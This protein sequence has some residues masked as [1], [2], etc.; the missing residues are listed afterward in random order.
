MQINTH[1]STL[2]LIDKAK[3]REKILKVAREKQQ[4]TYK[5]TTLESSIF[6]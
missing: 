5:K 6:H 1:P 4:I 2:Q 3:N